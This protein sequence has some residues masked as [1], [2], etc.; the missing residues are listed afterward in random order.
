MIALMANL[1]N[2]MEGVPYSEV[3]LLVGLWRRGNCIPMMW[4]KNIQKTFV[5]EVAFKAVFEFL[6]ELDR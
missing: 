1:Q 6:V 4:N 3:T 2:R 5:R